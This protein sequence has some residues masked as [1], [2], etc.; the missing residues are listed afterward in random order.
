MDPTKH[1]GEL[2]CPGSAIMQ[3]LDLL[4]NKGICNFVWSIKNSLLV[5]D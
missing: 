2:G 3:S 4:Y 5:H 1:N